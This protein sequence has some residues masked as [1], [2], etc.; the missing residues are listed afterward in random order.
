M[1][2]P[3]FFSA[4]RLKKMKRTVIKEFQFRFFRKIGYGNDLLRL[5][6]FR[7]YHKLLH[8]DPKDP[9]LYLTL[10]VE[11]DKGPYED[12]GV[13][14]IAYFAQM[15]DVLKEKGVCAYLFLL[16]DE[17]AENTG[18][19]R[20]I[21][22]EGHCIG[23][24][25][26]THPDLT[27]CSRK[28]TLKELKQCSDLYH[29]LTGETMPLVMRPPYGTIHYPLAKKLYKAGYTVMHWSLH[30]PDYEKTQPTWEDYEVNFRTHL[31]N[32]GVILQHSHSSATAE[33][34]GR[35]IDYCRA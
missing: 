13:D 7:V 15:L 6:D 25:T 33:N 1:G 22:D 19:L 31:H 2:K 12:E 28:E 29:Q 35:L 23:N 9:I 24:H 8:P 3:G 27:K 32:G 16:G 30:V 4:K 26:M 11:W 21:I 10:D 18:L 20:R 17:M 14:H 34:L 5:R